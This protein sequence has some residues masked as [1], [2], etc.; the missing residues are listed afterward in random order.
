[1]CKKLK[2]GGVVYL[3]LPD[4]RY[5]FDKDQTITPIEH[6]IEGY[7]ASDEVLSYFSPL[8]DGDDF[9]FILGKATYTP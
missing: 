7:E 5:T 8:P 2:P 3:V 6:L 9:I 4:K 1:L